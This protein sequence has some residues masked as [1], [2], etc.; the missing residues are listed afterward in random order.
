MDN[1]RQAKENKTQD[2]NSKRRKSAGELSAGMGKFPT[3]LTLNQREKAPYSVK[4]LKAFMCDGIS[5]YFSDPDELFRIEVRLGI[6]EMAVLCSVLYIH[7]CTTFCSN[8]SQQQAVVIGCQ[9]KREY[10]ML[11][12]YT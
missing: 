1:V 11:Q 8:D 3:W 12:D 10:F 2:P 9:K 7:T 6:M 4:N 5:P